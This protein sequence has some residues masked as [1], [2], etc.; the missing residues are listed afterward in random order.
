[1]KKLMIALAFVGFA[2]NAAAQG[3][4]EVP[5]HK[6]KVVTN[7]FG[8]NWFLQAGINYNA[9][10]SSQENL[11]SKNPFSSAR[12]AVGL[13]FAVGKWHTPGIGLRTKLQGFWGKQVNT[14]NNHKSYYFINTHEDLMF[15]FS[16]LIFGY[17]EKRVWNFI[18]YIG[19][20]LAS[21]VDPVNIEISYNA[22]ILN[23]F[24]INDRFAINFELYTAWFE[25]NFDNAANDPYD[26]H[27]KFSHRHWDKQFGLS[28]GFTY[29]LS[30]KRNWDKA[31]DVEAL[32]AMNQEQMD[33]LNASLREQQDENARLRDLLA[34]QKP[35]TA[36][37]ATATAAHGAEKVVCTSQ[38]VFFNIGSA[39]IAS[40]KD[41]VNV[42]EVADAKANGKKIHV[43][44][45]ADSKTGKPEFN[46]ALSEKR[47]QAVADELVK[48]G[49]SRDQI[50]VEA[51]GGVNNLTPFSYNRRT[52][53]TLM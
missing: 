22:G 4:T 38:S 28:V 5:V 13:D 49:V 36:T 20:G 24:R 51:K 12:G 43:V 31:P 53:V 3:T 11:S 33:A 35:A 23:T 1:M 26:S 15:N 8:A 37:A 45:Y 48:M 27:S 2:M 10:Y 16:N 21:S 29:Q 34:N 19:V 25:G 42:Q 46:Q 7:T 47:A 6:H 17:N 9:S 52:T 50:V 39:K 30:Q 41:L 14:A 40:R 32:M 18:P 44:G